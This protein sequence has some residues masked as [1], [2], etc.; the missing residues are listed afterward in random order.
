M[1][2]GMTRRGIARWIVV[3]LA[4]L[5]ASIPSSA[6]AARG[7]KQLWVARFNGAGNGPDFP[8]GMV[9]SPDGS[10]VFVTG[11]S[12]TGHA[13]DDFATIAYDASTGAQ[14]WLAV[15]D[16]SGGGDSASD[17]AVSPDS[18]IVYVVGRSADVTEDLAV[19]AY[20]AATGR[21]VWIAMFKPTRRMIEEPQEI[22][23]SPDGTQLFV[24]GYEVGQFDDTRYNTV[25]FSAATGDMQWYQQDV[26]RTGAD[27]L[28]IAFDLA[29]SPDGSHVF[30]TGIAGTAYGAEDATTVSYAAATGTRS[31]I[32]RYAGLGVSAG[33]SLV[34][35]PDGS[36]LYVTG[37]TQ[38]PSGSD[39]EFATLAYRASSGKRLWLRRYHGPKHSGV[40]QAYSV[41]VDPSGARVYV[42]GTSAGSLLTLAYD[43]TTGDTLWKTRRPRSGARGSFLA[44]SPNGSRLY[45]I[46]AMQALE[47]SHLEFVTVA[48]RTVDGS[49]TWARDYDGDASGDSQPESVAVSP[50]GSRVFVSGFSNGASSGFDYATVAY[51][52]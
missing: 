46:G 36:T 33:Q 12:H 15:Y 39:Q 52:P 22:V 24:T 40:D 44:V 45:V 10:M 37:G 19:I 1:T 11:Q 25:A 4:A 35:S 29:V 8:G 42:T 47:A 16:S 13:N 9:L 23:V 48:Y 43:A 51:S 2:P 30:V 7:G 5:L 27:P 28:G 6:G 31:W 18:K 34:T 38:N 21:Q 14:R 32:A 20:D 50:D 41:G 26:P 49:P 17:L 3:A